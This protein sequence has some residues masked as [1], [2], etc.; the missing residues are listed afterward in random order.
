MRVFLT[1]IVLLAL[2]VGSVAGEIRKGATMRVKA[3]SIWFQDTDRLT[4]WQALK[5]SGDSTALSSY[6]EEV[7]GNWDAWQFINPLTV[8][9]LSYKPREKSG[10]RGNEDFRPIAWHHMV[11]R[12]RCFDA[13]AHPSRFFCNAPERYSLPLL[14]NS[15]R[16]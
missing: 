1:L 16:M 6:Q 2:S 14:A 15:L 13:I 4:H 12:C 11:A 8:K 9:I 7:L 3:N 10:R 5:K